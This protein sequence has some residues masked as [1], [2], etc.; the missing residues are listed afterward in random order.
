M[1]ETII[2]KIQGRLD[3]QW[4]DWFD[5]MEICYEGNKTVLTGDK[6]DEAFVHGILNRIR[7][8]NLKLDSVETKSKKYEN[9]I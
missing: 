7:D 3:K 9:Y 5:G 6:K 2:I 1:S 8:L 4:K